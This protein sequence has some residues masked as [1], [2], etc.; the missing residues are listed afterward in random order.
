MDLYMRRVGQQLLQE[1]DVAKRV[2]SER[3]NDVQS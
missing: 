1:D 3:V 2:A